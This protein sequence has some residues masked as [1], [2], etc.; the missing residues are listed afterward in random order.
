MKSLIH[1]ST[2]LLRTVWAIAAAAV[3]LVVVIFII[4]SRV[5]AV[6]AQPGDGSHLITIHDRGNQIV[7][8]T[9]GTT[10]GDA[11]KQAGIHVDS[12]DAVEPAASEKLVASEYDVNIY[13][14]RPVVVVDGAT[15]QKVVTPYQSAEQIAKSAGITLY[16][17]DKT[18]LT[19]TNDIVAEG[20]GLKL[21]ITRAIPFNFTLY[22]ASSIARTQAKTVGDM[23]KEKGVTLTASDRVSPGA[24]AAITANMDI[25]VWREGKQTITQAETVAFSTQQ[26]QDGDQPVGYQQ[27]QTPGQDGTKNVTYEITIIDG[28]EASRTAIASVSTKDAVAQVIVIGT[29]LVLTR[30]YS[31]QKVQIMTA[32]GVAVS[33]QG[34]AAYIL[35]HENASWCPT[36]WQGTNGCPAAY[37]PLYAENAQVGYGLCQATPGD[38]MA[39]AGSDWKTNPITQ[40]QWCASYAFGRYGSWAA[41]YNYW[42]SHHNW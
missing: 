31:A 3:F 10:V 34:Y 11:L 6:S 17:E 8:S 15:R 40:L 23:L 14:A 16:D 27:I 33:D 30:G 26:V 32:A 7:V 28:K 42:V 22:G 24:Q 5:G 21:T 20:A 2:T 9:R 37:N 4:V 41:A 18:T 19:L 36:R 12:V 39:T 29:K 35:D 38:K 13:R 25:H 1:R